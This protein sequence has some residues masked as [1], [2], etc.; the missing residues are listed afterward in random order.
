MLKDQNQQGTPD[1][2][3]EMPNGSKT[4]WVFTCTVK[5]SQRMEL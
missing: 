1:S 5:S 3:A 2:K 4:I